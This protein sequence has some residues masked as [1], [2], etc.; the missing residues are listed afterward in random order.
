ML[1]GNKCDLDDLRVI[2]TER[3][4]EAAERYNIP[5]METSALKDIN[6]KNAFYTMTRQL[7]E[8]VSYY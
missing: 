7:I 3:G 6:I 8:I 4:L 1:I 2:S 5:F